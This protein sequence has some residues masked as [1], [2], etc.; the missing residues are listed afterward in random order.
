MNDDF[1]LVLSSRNLTREAELD[2]DCDAACVGT[3]PRCDVR[4]RR[5]QV[6]EPFELDLRRLEGGLWEL[7]CSDGIYLSSGDAQRRA[8]M[9]LGHGGSVSVRY[10]STNATLFALELN[11]NFDR[12]RGSY[13]RWVDMR[14]LDVLSIGSMPGCSLVLD[15]PYTQGDLLFVQRAGGAL[16]LVERQS[17]YGVYCDG[18]RV[19]GQVELRNRSFFSVANFHFYYVD[20]RLHYSSAA[21][22]RPHGVVVQDMPQRGARGGYPRFNRSTRVK[23]LI[24]IDPVPVLDPPDEPHKPQ[25][26]I[27]LR[28]LPSV[29]MLAIAVFLRPMIMSSTSMNAM[30]YALVSA[31]SVGV[32][33]ISSIATYVVESRRYKRGMKEREETYRGY[34]EEKREEVDA[35]HAT[36]LE[37]LGRRY[38]DVDDELGMV[39]DFSGRLFERRAADEDFLHV[40]MGV[41]AREASQQVDFQ[42]RETFEPDELM[43]LPEALRNECRYLAQAPI[44]LDLRASGAVGVVGPQAKALAFLNNMVVDLAVRQHD[45]E[46]KLV[47]VMEP[48]REGLVSWARL[49]PHVQ[50][51]EL[52]R[53][54]F[55]CDQESRNTL[56]EYLLTVLMGRSSVRA[57]VLLPHYVVFLID[58]TGFQNHPVSRFV[59]TA[60]DLGVSFVFFAR[61]KEQLPLGCKKLVLLDRELDEGMLVDTQNDRD[62]Q[63]FS[64][65]PVERAAAATMATTLAPV[66]CEEVSLE[67][68]LTKSITLFE[69]L[70]IAAAEDLDLQERW[71]AS[72]VHRSL[73]APIGVSK[74]GTVELDLHDKAHGPHGLVAGTTGSGKSETLQTYI[75]SMAALYHPYE[76]GFVIIDFKGGGMVNQ[77]R[78]LPHLMGAI[79]NIDGREIDRSLK[80]IKAELQKRQRLFAAAGV[81]HIDAYIKKFKAGAVSEPLPHLII[82]VD[83]FAELKAEQPEFMKELIS[84]SRIGRSL[85]VHLILATQ[86]PAGQVNEQIWSNSR[87]KLCLKVASAQ[88]S[89]EVIKSPLAAEIKEAGRAYLQVGNNEI[90]ELFQS[91]Y[92]GAP[93]RVDEA[94]VREFT[95]YEVDACGRRTPIYTRRRARKDAAGAT[96]LEALVGHVAA[97]CERAGIAQLPS[98]CLPALE[99]R[100]EFPAVPAFDE[101]GMAVGIYDDPENQYQGALRLDIENTNTFI[102]GS[103]QMGKTNLLQAMVRGIAA[104][105]T[106]EQAAIYIMDFGSMILKNFEQL[107]HVGGVVLPTED[108][109]VKNLFK[110]LGEE[111][112]RRRKRLLDA[113]VSTYSAYVELGNTDLPHLYL[114]LDNFAVFRELY[115][116]R[117]EADLLRL[118]RDGIAY[119]ITL[120]VTNSVTTGFGFRY[121]SNF[122]TCVALSCNDRG[123]YTTVFGRCRM[124]PKNVPG[125]ALCQIDKSVYE[126]QTYLA[127]AGEREV[128]RVAAM[129]AFVQG[130]NARG[131]GS[132]ARRIPSVPDVLSY[133]YLRENYTLAPAEL[134]FALDYATVEPVRVP[135][136]GQL[137][138][139]VVGKDAAARQPVVNALMGSL[140][141]AAF[142]VPL[143]VFVVDDFV[144]GLAPWA[145][146]P[147]VARYTTDYTQAGELLEELNARLEARYAA[148]LEHGIEALGQEPY[149]VAVLNAPDAISHLSDSKELMALYGG[150][151][152]KYGAMRAL[153]VFSGVNDANVPFSGAPLLKTLKEERRGFVTTPLADQK[154]F[155]VNAVTARQYGRQLEEGQAFFVEG[156]D[157]HKVKL[158]Q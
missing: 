52:G 50:N 82:I 22:I 24:P 103:A 81:N 84:A 108:E 26:D 13:D 158:A 142:E 147:F 133:S 156:T 11:I 46:L 16:L 51:E 131:T 19:D 145:E 139:S 66:Y 64:Y 87:F 41:G 53:R 113:G 39:R 32:S 117:Y 127:F 130:V 15:G 68:E 116:E 34:I 73:A 48:G 35:L 75:L 23:T 134:A 135:L 143:E 93:E 126:F 83:E 74:A 91:A 21:A 18:R 99:E 137:S 122:S 106:P 148:V 70:G 101:R 88:D 63:E 10:A 71:A 4:F 149:L 92:S 20:G 97:Y 77:F 111:L 2:A 128:D 86:K 102:V 72:A 3:T 98:I 125:R 5:E 123:E 58:E 44:A 76:V 30:S 140:R 55:A 90:F 80:S 112:T 110:L 150:M 69:L 146:A 129:R 17:R 14:G 132:H 47:F 78:N 25:G 144:R 1:L 89:N 153:I 61:T 37:V 56:F 100:I 152:K 67:G 109:R 124:E 45:S 40:R 79:T 114:M 33:I 96:Q 94:A 119:G 65:E 59:D 118:A 136:V 54:N 60:A 120:V 95:L 107:D 36:E 104:T 6:P 155:E 141:E 38:P 138:L 105:R 157:V 85:G 42:V 43:A 27:A 28:L 29:G 57:P 7:S 8:I 9:Q 49:L 151:A 31:A 115:A 12:E 121:L 62:T 154:F